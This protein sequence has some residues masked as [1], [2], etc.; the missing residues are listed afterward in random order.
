MQDR[1]E[2][3]ALG[4]VGQKTGS[5]MTTAWLMLLLAAPK[6]Q[7]GRWPLESRALPRVP[8]H[9]HR[10][11]NPGFGSR[12]PSYLSSAVILNCTYPGS[13]TADEIAHAGARQES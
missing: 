3:L 4:R 9:P 5:A 2:D 11:A 8:E 12:L 7:D 1:E 10:R 6:Q 13:L